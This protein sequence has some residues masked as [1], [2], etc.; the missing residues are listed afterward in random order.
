MQRLRCG[1]KMG[2]EERKM[3]GAESDGRERTGDPVVIKMSVCMEADAHLPSTHT[4]AHL[5]LLRL[6]CE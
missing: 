2:R 3:Q 6:C 5:H 4:Q 1:D